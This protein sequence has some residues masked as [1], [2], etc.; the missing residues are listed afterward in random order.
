MNQTMNSKLNTATEA[1][2]GSKEKLSKEI[3]GMANAASDLLKNFSAQDLDTARAALSKAQTA[4]SDGAKQYA[5]MTDGYV[6]AN[7]WKTVGVA[8][9]AGLLIGVLLA[10]R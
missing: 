10:R 7:P 3:D 1:F 6:R 5:D 8:A 4:I 2:Q 9:A